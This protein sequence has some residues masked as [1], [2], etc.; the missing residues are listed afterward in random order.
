MADVLDIGDSDSQK[1]V[2]KGGKVVDQIVGAVP[3]SRIEDV[4]RKKL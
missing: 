4:V 1:Q 3:K 2:L